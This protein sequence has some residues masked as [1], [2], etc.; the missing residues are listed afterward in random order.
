M[1]ILGPKK[2]IMKKCNCK[3]IVCNKD[4][5]PCHKYNKKCSKHCKCTT[6][7]NKQPKYHFKTEV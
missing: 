7:E 2:S 4:Y 6:C 5:C 3:R 1:R